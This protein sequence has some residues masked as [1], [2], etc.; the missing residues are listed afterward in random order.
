[1]TTRNSLRRLVAAAGCVA[2]TATGCAFHGLNSLPLPGT[3]GRGSGAGV[4]HV[5]LANVGTLEPNSPVLMSDVVVGSISKMT[6]RHWHADV[7][8]SLKPGVVV[9]ANSLAAVGQTSL[10]G[11]MHL[12]LDPPLGQAPLGHL[13]PGATIGLNKSATYPS[14]EQTLSSLAAIVNGGGL[15]QVG[16]IIHNFNVALDGRTGDL[17]DLLGRLNNLVDTLDGQRDNITAVIQGLNRF[18]TTLARQCDVLSRALQGIPPALD[19]LVNE[20]PRITTALAKLGNLSDVAHRLVTD[21][22]ADLITNLRN[23]APVLRTL[24][25]V[26]PGLDRAVS[27]ATTFPYTQNFVDRAVRGDYVNLFLVIDDTIPRLKRSMLLGTRW[28]NKD[29][30]LVPAPG[31][32]WYLNYSHDPLGA[33]VAP[34][35]PKPGL[36][37]QNIVPSA[38]FVPPNAPAPSPPPAPTGSGG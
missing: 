9:P 23:L 1:M 16:D 32:P 29:A 3:V 14:T 31:D 28:G 18:S 8:I 25:D 19:V 30:V 33:G 27:L 37:T 22:Q 4:Y 6:V 17:R 5:E 2:L 26:G 21:S 20:R 34:S 38:P 12:S 7:E 15:G 11:S 35:I 36:G 13:N 24:A 10:L